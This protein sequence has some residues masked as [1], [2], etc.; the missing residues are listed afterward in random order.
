MT[1]KIVMTGSGNETCFLVT[2]KNYKTIF[3]LRP[4][5]NCRGY[6]FRDIPG[7]IKRVV[8]EIQGEIQKENTL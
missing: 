4:Y 8:D 3:E 1:V 7:I 5:E 6:S 2:D